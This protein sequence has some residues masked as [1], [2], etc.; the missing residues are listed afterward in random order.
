MPSLSPSVDQNTTTSNHNIQS[1]LHKT[2][3]WP[4]ILDY[5]STFLH[6]AK[7]RS[8]NGVIIVM[9]Y[10]DA[11]NDAL[12]AEIVKQ[13]Q[14]KDRIVKYH[15]AEYDWQDANCGKFG[16]GGD[17]KEPTLPIE[18]SMIPKL[19]VPIL[20]QMLTESTTSDANDELWLK[21]QEISEQLMN[22]QEI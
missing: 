18:N 12:N 5:L 17:P 16:P 13:P 10:N 22:L 4:E 9:N 8:Y 3:M 21:F 14:N 20:R 7:R 19:V 2:D 15:V 1:K 11:L 6:L